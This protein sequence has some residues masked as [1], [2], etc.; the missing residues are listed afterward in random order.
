MITTNE[1]NP[2]PDWSVTGIGTGICDTV[3][4]AVRLGMINASYLCFA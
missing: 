4:E 1:T 3:V 2:M